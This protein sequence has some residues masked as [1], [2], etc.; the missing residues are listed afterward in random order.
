M[1]SCGAYAQDPDVEALIDESAAV[2]V[3]DLSET[4]DNSVEAQVK[5]VFKGSINPGDTITFSW[6]N[7][8][9]SPTDFLT[10]PPKTM[11][12]L[13]ISSASRES[14]SRSLTALTA[15]LIHPLLYSVKSLPQLASEHESINIPSVWPMRSALDPTGTK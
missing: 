15:C 13:Y 4:G 11:M 10:A 6:G 1:V 7:D 9:G 14:S 5:D 12:N 2:I 3:G 8:C